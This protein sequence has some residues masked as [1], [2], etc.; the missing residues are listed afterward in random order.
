VA[1]DVVAVCIAD[2]VERVIE[3]VV[4]NRHTPD[5]FRRKHTG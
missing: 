5:R 4:K 2:A 1:Q 3:S